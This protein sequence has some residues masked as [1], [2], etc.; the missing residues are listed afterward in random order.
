MAKKTLKALI[1]DIDDTVYSTTEFALM[2]RKNAVQAM[3]KAGLR[4]DEDECLHELEEVLREFGS[5]YEH[6]FDKLIQRLPPET[7]DPGASVILVAAGMVAYHQTKFRNFAPY[8]DAIEVLRQLKARNLLLAIVTSGIG[9]KQAEK[10][11]RLDLHHLVS[12]QYIFITDVIGIS[13]TNPKLYMRA[14][15]TLGVKP[16]QAVYVGDNP[17]VDVDV[18]KRIGMKTILSRRTGKYLEV[19]GKSKPDHIVH[20]FWDVLEVIDQYYEIKV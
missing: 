10:I 7:Y 2:A 15:K 8:E 5:N 19:E 9:I 6:H 17:V 16:E 11:V 14:C 13:K 18:P 3:I 1:F 4:V 12:P 20:N